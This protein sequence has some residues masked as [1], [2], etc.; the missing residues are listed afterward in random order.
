[1]AS[2][3]QL[4][5]AFLSS[6][7]GFVIAGE[8]GSG[9]GFGDHIA[10]VSLE[11]AYGIATDTNK[12][13]MLIIHKTWCGAC[14]ALKPKF[15]DSTEIASLSKHFV[16]VNTEDD[17]EPTDS[18]FSPDGGY[19]PRILFLDSNGEVDQTVTNTK[20]NPKYKYYYPEPKG[21]LHSMREVAKANGAGV[22]NDEL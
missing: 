13:I 1:M 21:I 22:S 2:W 20:G 4:I 18:K 15:A 7:L 3:K 9:K 17:E 5:F 8:P 11:D 10:W 14:K 6:F 12:P 16:M 19:I